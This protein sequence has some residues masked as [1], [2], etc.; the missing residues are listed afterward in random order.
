MDAWLQTVNVVILVWLLGRFFCRPVVD[1]VAKRQEETNK[2]LADAA[3]AR[4][5][6]AGCP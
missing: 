3:A 6:A 2:L 5:E 4:Q 1:I